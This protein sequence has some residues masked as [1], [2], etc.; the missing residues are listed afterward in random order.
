MHKLNGL[1]ENCTA[2]K[3]RSYPSVHLSLFP[4]PKLGVC[5]SCGYWVHHMNSAVDHSR[6]LLNAVRGTA[7]SD[8]INANY[9]DVS[10]GSPQI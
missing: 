10:L 2:A 4:F 3:C 1:E 8:Y 6:V 9:I 5:F 7:G